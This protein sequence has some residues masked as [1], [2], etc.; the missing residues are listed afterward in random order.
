MITHIT[1][2]RREFA[3]EMFSEHKIR[4]CLLNVDKA[5]LVNYTLVLVL[6]LILSSGA[7][8]E[9]GS[10]HFCCTNSHSVASNVIADR[11]LRWVVDVLIIYL[12]MLIRNVKAI[13]CVY[14]NPQIDFFFWFLRALIWFKTIQNRKHFIQDVGPQ[15]FWKDGFNRYACSWNL[16]FIS[17]STYHHLHC[18]HCQCLFT[19]QRMIPDCFNDIGSKKTWFYVRPIEADAPVV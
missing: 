2:W 3:E 17:T 9:F 10:W 15:N 5:K 11:T 12:Q 8:N 1:A 6:G 19:W 4:T 18:I 7:N 16:L 14:T 13:D